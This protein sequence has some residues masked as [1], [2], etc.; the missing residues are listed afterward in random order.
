MFRFLGLLGLLFAFALACFGD[1]VAGPTVD[2]FTTFVDTNTGVEW[3]TLNNFYG[4]NYASQLSNLPSGFHVATFD[5]VNALATGSMPDVT[6]DASWLSYNS[7]VMG[8][9][10]RGLI[11]GNYAVSGATGPN[12]WF[13]SYQDETWS[14]QTSV[15]D[16]GAFTDLGLWASNAAASS[17]PEPGTAVLLVGAGALLW[18]R[19]RR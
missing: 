18:I 11:W 2:G 15:G 12:G 4:E 17:V 19:R 5:Q 7:I 8:S 1:V 10:S 3:L 6:S 13:W 9:T 16:T 14:F